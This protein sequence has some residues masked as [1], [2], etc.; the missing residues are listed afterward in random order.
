MYSKA[1]RVYPIQ[2]L[3]RVSDTLREWRRDWRPS[4]DENIVA[5]LDNASY[6]KGG[7]YE[8][9]LKEW[10]WSVKY[11]A[12][13]SHATH[14]AEPFNRV[15]LFTTRSLLEDAQLPLT[16]WNFA[17][18]TACYLYNRSS[19]S[20]EAK[21]PYERHNGVQPDISHLRIFGS[22]AVMKNHTVNRKLKNRGTDAVFL[23]YPTRSSY[24]SYIV[25]NKD[26]GAI[27]VTR[28]VEIFDTI[29][30]RNELKGVADASK[31]QSTEPVE[32]TDTQ[33]ARAAKVV[34]AYELVWLPYVISKRN[35]YGTVS[36]DQ[37]SIESELPDATDDQMPTTFEMEEST[38]PDSADLGAEMHIQSNANAP[39]SASTSD[40]GSTRYPSRIRNARQLMNVNQFGRATDNYDYT[41]PFTGMVLDKSLIAGIPPDVKEENPSVKRKVP[42]VVIEEEVAP[43]DFKD[44]TNMKATSKYRWWESMNN[45][46]DQLVRTGT[47]ELVPKSEAT[48]SLMGTKWVYTIKGDMSYKSRLCV[49]GYNEPIESLAEIYSATVWN[50]TTLAATVVALTLGYETITIDFKQAFVQAELTE[51]DALYIRPPDG[52][53]IDDNKVIR[54]RRSLYGLKS[55]SHRWSNVLNETMGKL[56][57][58]QS[59][60]DNA[61]YIGKDIIG[62]GHVDDLRVFGKPDV[63]EQFVKN[64]KD[65]HEI[66]IH[67]PQEG[68]EDIYLGNKWEFSKAAKRCKISR[69]KYIEENLE[70]YGLKDAKPMNTP[71]DSGTELLD[72]DVDEKDPAYQQM[73]GSL[74]FVSRIRPD[75][76]FAMSQLTRHN[77]RNGKVHMQNAKRVWRYLKST[78]QNAFNLRGADK[79][80]DLE[81]VV[82]SDASFAPSNDPKRKG[83]SGTVITLGKTLIGWSS[84]KQSIAALSSHEAEMIALMYSV[85]QALATRNMLEDLGVCIKK[86]RVFSDNQSVIEDIKRG[87]W[88]NRT[89][90]LDIRYLRLALLY[91]TGQIS[92]E[93]VTTEEMIADS[94][95]KALAA[96]KFRQFTD[97]LMNAEASV[98]ARL[99]GG[100]MND[101][102]NMI[103]VE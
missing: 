12:P 97:L 67:I 101:D 40:E 38:S 1:I 20:R 81:L 51:E 4:K 58:K 62:I 56:G 85:Q 34:S 74:L 95:T 48:T 98:P 41:A 43:K 69:T 27:C 23:G 66:T 6:Y 92:M 7:K 10:S 36:V 42:P 17:Y 63:I 33:Q 77:H 18:L 102:S 78:K 39:S 75:I 30:N 84:K 22:P 44:W 99:C 45:E 46:W 64:L 87:Q 31:R 55:A 16:Y 79:I 96:P 15:L 11:C 103:S 50:T 70:K 2:D 72:H 100:V 83:T 5:Y 59:P 89:R 21:T 3:N 49:K 93:Y 71:M 32:V 86:I 80:E 28:D 25:L 24:G 13:N 68:K 57:F 37:E 82:W 35:Q 29:K 90:H 8:D 76:S 54:L 65:R 60:H 47:F 53:K 73:I 9:L 19:S 26:T 14:P 88:T 91:R 94:M 52:V 61:L